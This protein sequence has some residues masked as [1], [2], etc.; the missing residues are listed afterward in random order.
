MFF[1]VITWDGQG[2][3]ESL[4]MHRHHGGEAGLGVYEC[5]LNGC[6]PSPSFDASCLSAHGKPIRRYELPEVQGFIWEVHLQEISPNFTNSTA[7]EPTHQRHEENSWTNVWGLLAPHPCVGPWL[8]TCRVRAWH[9][10]MN[11]SAYQLSDWLIMVGWFSWTLM[12]TK[13]DE[14]RVLIHEHEL[15]NT[16]QLM[17][18]VCRFLVQDDQNPLRQDTLWRQQTMASPEWRMRAVWWRHART[19]PG[20][21]RV[22]S[23]EPTN[24]AA[25]TLINRTDW[26]KLETEVESLAESL[27]HRH[28]SFWLY[29]GNSFRKTK[30]GV[31]KKYTH[32]GCF[33]SRHV[34]FRFRGPHPLQKR[35]QFL[36]QIA[37]THCHLH[38]PSLAMINHHSSTIQHYYQLAI[39]TIIKP[40]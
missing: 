4:N 27:T 24:S 13:P 7:T 31:A 6:N 37:N 3:V 20:G 30:V 2:N 26:L 25:M 32:K 23:S 35:A 14:E 21:I 22:P 12:K 16:N 38:Y 33:W 36:N 1:S 11:T 28:V 18:P 39:V 17:Y 19:S 34:H 10:P 9:W 15:M 40:S 8:V 5:K 29:T